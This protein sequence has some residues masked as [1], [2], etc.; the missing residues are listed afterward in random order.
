M[1]DIKFII[2]NKQ[3]VREGLDK[4]GYTDIDLDNLISL[5]S[6]I[7]KL[8]TSSQALAEEKNKEQLYQISFARGT[9][10][11]YCQE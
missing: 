4:K 8:K 10:R 9:S 11:D 6:G 1:L 3:L 2:E 5:H 7:T